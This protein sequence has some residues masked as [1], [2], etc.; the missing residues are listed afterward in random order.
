MAMSCYPTS[1]HLLRNQNR[2]K[3]PDVFKPV[4]IYI[5][6][7]RSSSLNK[8][9]GAACSSPSQVYGRHGF[10]N[11]PIHEE[12]G[13]LPWFWTR[14]YPTQQKNTFL[15]T[16]GLVSKPMRLD[17]PVQVRIIIQED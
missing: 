12:V 10:D 9:P 2:G 4:G 5:P 1:H 6:S 15:A 14:G 7:E 3:P 8:F 13:R 11:S 16:R 17:V